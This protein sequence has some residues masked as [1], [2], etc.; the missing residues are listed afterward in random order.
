MAP[1][2]IGKPNTITPEAFQQTRT[3]YHLLLDSFTPR[4]HSPEEC[5]A[6]YDRLIK[7]RNFPTLVLFDW[8]KM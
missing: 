5:A 4:T 3:R 2:K 1:I 7:E 6:V 8:T